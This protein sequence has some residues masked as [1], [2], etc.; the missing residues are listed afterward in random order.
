VLGR[1]WGGG[2]EIA[3]QCGEE[4]FGTMGW[5]NKLHMPRKQRNK[6]ND[7]RT[8]RH[9]KIK[10]FFPLLLKHKERAEIRQA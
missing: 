10:T 4:T 5:K 3:A 6:V 2:T 7:K 9:E 8:A 1:W